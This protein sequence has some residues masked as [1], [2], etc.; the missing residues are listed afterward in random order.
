MSQMI[1]LAIHTVVLGYWLGSDL[2]INSEY[3][4][5]V[6]RNDLPV[7]ARQEMTDHL[8]KVDQHVRYAL[9][10]QATLG[11]MLLAGL[12]L[13]P[14]NLGGIAFV[15]GLAWLGLVEATHRTRKI[16]LG[17]RLA[18]LDRVVR[19]AVALA[20]LALAATQGDWPAWLRLKLV[21]FA[22]VIGC[23]LLIRFQLIRHFTVWGEVLAQGSTPGREASLR[24]TYRRATT[25][26][27]CLWLQVFS[28]AALAVLRPF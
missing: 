2:V 15:A 27:A 16:A 19:Y 10:L 9:V 3:R 17:Q 7:A 25:I 4:F 23:G 6:H 28:I 14:A 1:L 8:M 24:A 20:L 5:I 11:T 12:G 13:L 22:G 21:L 26:L 18:L